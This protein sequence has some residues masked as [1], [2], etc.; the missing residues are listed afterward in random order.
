M[1]YSNNNYDHFNRMIGMFKIV[2]H[3]LLN[4]KYLKH[5]CKS[6]KKKTQPHF[7]MPSILRNLFYD[8]KYLIL[9]IIKQ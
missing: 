7:G 8:L 4:F 9:H 3:M 1:V 2:S 5:N 6:L